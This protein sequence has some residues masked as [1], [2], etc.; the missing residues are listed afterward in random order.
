VTSDRRAIRRFRLILASFI[1]V[2]GIALGRASWLQ[3]VHA[4]SYGALAQRLH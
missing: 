4:A 1:V 3:V 2:F